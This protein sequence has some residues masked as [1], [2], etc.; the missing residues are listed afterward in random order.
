MTRRLIL[1]VRWL[2]LA[3]TTIGLAAGCH[4]R[5]RI[6]MVSYSN[7]PIATELTP[8]PCAPN[9]AVARLEAKAATTRDDNSANATRLIVRVVSADSGDARPGAMV[10][11]GDRRASPTA[12]V[13]VYAFDSL[14]PGRQIVRARA[15]GFQAL[16]DSLL[17]RAGF[18]DTLVAHL[19]LWCR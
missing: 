6:V 10:L 13:G 18:T 5:S 14:S 1:R 19:A 17:V 7:M 15:I 2:L 9:A 4:R 11:I 8:P 16:T 3:S 12:D